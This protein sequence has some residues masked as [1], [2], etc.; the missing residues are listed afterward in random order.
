MMRLLKPIWTVVVAGAV[1][2]GA[3]GVAAQ[4]KQPPPAKTPPAKKTTPVVQ[5]PAPASK[6]PAKTT[7]APAKT[8]SSA[9]A[10]GTSTQATKAPAKA[11]AASAPAGAAPAAS[12]GDSEMKPGNRRDPFESLLA[13]RQ[14]EGAA[15]EVTCRAPGKGGI[16]IDT[17]RLEGVVRSSQVVIAVV[18]TPQQRVYFLRDGDRLCDG[19]VEKISMDGMTLR[20]Q[21]RDAFGKP[22][23]RPVS[24]RLFPSAGE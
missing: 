2:L 20:Q 17:M 19:R 7:A 23:E 5:T 3:A 10:K 22:I 16:V 15:P 13:G 12:A 14:R 1:S 6:A 11:P 18:K 9:P 4:A 21:S 8:T 24:K